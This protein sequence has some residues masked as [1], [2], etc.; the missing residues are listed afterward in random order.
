MDDGGHRSQRPGR[1]DGLTVKHHLQREL[2]RARKMPEACFG[3][4]RGME[5]RRKQR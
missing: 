1:E 2:D 3:R 5:L 4:G